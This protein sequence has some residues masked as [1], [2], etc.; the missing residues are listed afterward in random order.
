MSDRNNFRGDWDQLKVIVEVPGPEEAGANATR[1][2]TRFFAELPM[3]G[4]GIV[5]TTAVHPN[6]EVTP[7]AGELIAILVPH[8]S[9]PSVEEKLQDTLLAYRSLWEWASKNVIDGEEAAWI[10]TG[11]PAI[12]WS[13]LRARGLVTHEVVDNE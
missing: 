13:E 11:Q 12:V 7:T 8:N 10:H 2:A 5:D 6:L 3:V 4:S 1:A 9:E